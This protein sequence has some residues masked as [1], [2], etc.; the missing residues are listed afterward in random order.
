MNE[1]NEQ[2]P[3]PA[4]SQLK[5]KGPGLAVIGRKW[6]SIE[7][8]EI[9]YLVGQILLDGFSMGDT[10][11]IGVSGEVCDDGSVRCDIEMLAISNELPEV[12]GFHWVDNFYRYLS[13]YVEHNMKDAT[14][15]HP[16]Q[17]F[18]MNN[19]DFWESIPRNVHLMDT[20]H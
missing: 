18:C 9:P 3:W 14:H 19:G 11:K 20:Q 17:F 4:R 6:L 5:Q 2:K 10:I 8:S 13:A 15:F 16:V 1:F 12:Y 7:I